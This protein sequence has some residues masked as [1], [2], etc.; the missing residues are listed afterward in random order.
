MAKLIV[1]A[2]KP[3]K[4]KDLVSPSVA[5]K[6]WADAVRESRKDA[7]ELRARRNRALRTS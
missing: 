4:A 2:P 3:T 6:I 7:T 1:E 5:K